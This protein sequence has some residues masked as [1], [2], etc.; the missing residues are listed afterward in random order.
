MKSAWVKN[1]KS[2]T[3]PPIL[4]KTAAPSLPIVNLPLCVKAVTVAVK[5][6]VVQLMGLPAPLD[7]RVIQQFSSYKLCDTLIP[8][9]THSALKFA[10]FT[11]H[12][13]SQFTSRLVLTWSSV[14]V[15]NA[16]K[17]LSPI[18]LSPTDVVRKRQYS[19]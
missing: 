10:M 6:S 3:R 14:S 12:W 18:I 17:I 11:L 5:V 1:L 13:K 4:G 19:F 2:T 15:T 16:V 9:W 7:H 8:M